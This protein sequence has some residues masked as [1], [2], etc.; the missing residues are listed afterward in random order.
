MG[1]SLYQ[2]LGGSERSLP[3]VT[4]HPVKWTKRWQ[5]DKVMTTASPLGAVAGWKVPLIPLLLRRCYAAL[6]CGFHLEYPAILE[7]WRARKLPCYSNERRRVSVYAVRSS[8]RNRKGIYWVALLCCFCVHSL[9]SATTA[10]LY[11]GVTAAP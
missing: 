9:R 10:A 4:S 7:A 6:V 1:W 2:N 3:A 8:H 11:I 5:C